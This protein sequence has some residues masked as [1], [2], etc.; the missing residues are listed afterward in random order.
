MTEPGSEHGFDSGEKIDSRT[1][2]IYVDTPGLL[3]AVVTTTAGL[4]DAAAA[5]LVLE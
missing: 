4:D 2:H 5:P 1:C 3:L